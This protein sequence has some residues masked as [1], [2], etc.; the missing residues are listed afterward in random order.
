[1]Q[2]CTIIPIK[3]ISVAVFILINLSF[4][5]YLSYTRQKKTNSHPFWK[6]FT[7]EPPPSETLQKYGRGHHK[8]IYFNLSVSGNSG[9]SPCY[10]MV[11]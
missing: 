6:K 7:K 4:I 11:L 3:A 1:M 5:N 2:K 8:M 10:I 9:E